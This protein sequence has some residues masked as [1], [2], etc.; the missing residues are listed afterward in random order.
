VGTEER[1]EPSRESSIDLPINMTKK[2]AEAEKLS[3]VFLGARQI[4]FLPLWD[5]SGGVQIPSP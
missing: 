1:S 2:S 5:A 3:R 4:I